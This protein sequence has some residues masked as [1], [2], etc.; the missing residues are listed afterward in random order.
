MF[1]LKQQGCVHYIILQN[2]FVIRQ[3]QKCIF[4]LYCIVKCQTHDQEV[5]D[6]SRD[7]STYVNDS[8]Q[9]VLTHVPLSP[10]SIIWYWPKIT[11]GVAVV[12]HV[13]Q[14]PGDWDQQLQP[15]YHVWNCLLYTSPSPRD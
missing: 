10:S 2:K 11:R 12:Y 9:V 1:N 4:V 13:G 8:W 6:L 15:L 14:L 3:I 7:C 5:A